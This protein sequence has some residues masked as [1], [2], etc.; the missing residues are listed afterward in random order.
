[1]TVLYVAPPPPTI[2]VEPPP[3]VLVPRLRLLVEGL[4]LDILPRNRLQALPEA[5]E[6]PLPGEEA[7]VFRPLAPDNRARALRPLPPEQL[8]P[9]PVPAKPDAPKPDAPK[10]AP[11]PSAPPQLPRPPAP[12]DD[13]QAEYKRL[14][15]LGRTAFAAQEY[16]RAAQRFQQATRIAPNQPLAHFLLAQV[17]LALGKYRDAV[18]AIHGGLARQPDWPTVRFQPLELYG[19]NVAD[20]PEHLRRLEEVLQ[21][22]PDDPVLLFLYAYQLWFDGRKEEARLLF[23]RALPGAADPDVIQGF[24]RALPAAPA[25]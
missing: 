19:P 24:L 4:P 17:L 13:P 2:V 22:H 6:P 10:P 8:P 18:E 15:G 1:V 5:P 16:G 21:H 11:K 3:I 7:G 23:Q 25:V 20:Y 14:L 12:E 9:K